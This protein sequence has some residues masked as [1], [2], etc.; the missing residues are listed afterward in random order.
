[1]YVPELGRGPGCGGA[2]RLLCV[3]KIA[4]GQRRTNVGRAFIKKSE[5]W[6]SHWKFDE[7]PKWF[8]GPNFRNCHFV[9]LRSGF[10][11]VLSTDTSKPLVVGMNEEETLSQQTGITK[12]NSFVSFVESSNVSELLLVSSPSSGVLN[13]LVNIYLFL[14]YLKTLEALKENGM[15]R[16][17]PEFP[18]EP[19]LTVDVGRSSCPWSWPCWDT[20]NPFGFPHY[21]LEVLQLQFEETL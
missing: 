15:D 3:G 1:M 19:G 8:M 11:I 12:P 9:T 7:L 17:A 16:R 10:R 2:W 14:T 6:F 5:V 18:R 4:V 20:T 13:L 21:P